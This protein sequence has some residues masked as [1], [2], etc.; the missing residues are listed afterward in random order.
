MSPRRRQPLAEWGDLLLL[1]YAFV[2]ICATTLQGT[3]MTVLCHV[4]VPRDWW[5]AGVGLH[6][7]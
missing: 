5:G 6:I 1:S 2:L 7:R 3:E 4:E